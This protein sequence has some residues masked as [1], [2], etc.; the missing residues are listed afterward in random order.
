[1]KKTLFILSFLSATS[2]CS[3]SQNVGIGT[4]TPNASAAL[5][6][7]STSKGLEIVFQ[8]F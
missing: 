5:D 7:Q 2:Y 4:T 6:V 1:M 8:H 3:F